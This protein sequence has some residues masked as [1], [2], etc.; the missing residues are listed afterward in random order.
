MPEVI[1][2]PPSGATRAELRR[3]VEALQAGS[4]AALPDETGYLVCGSPLHGD[5]MEQLGA[6]APAGRLSVFVSDPVLAED[7][8]PPGF[9]SGAA[10]RLARRC[11][12]G[13]IVLEFP[14]DEPNSAVA[15]WPGGVRSAVTRGGRVRLGCSAQGFVRDVARELPWPLVSTA[16]SNE[17]P[18]ER[19]ESAAA[20]QQRCGARVALIVDAGSPRYQDRATVVRIE[21]QGWSLAEEGIVG[22]RTVAQLAS[23]IIVFICTGNTCRSPMAEGM[24]RKLLAQRLNCSEEQLTDR[25][26]VVLS[27]GLA[28]TPG[29]GANEIAVELMREDGIDLTSHQS[30][31]A[32]PDLL[33]VADHIVTMT[34]SHRE[35]IV[36]RFP[37][38]A[39][40]V[41]V[42]ADDGAD[43]FDPFGGDRSEYERCRD[44]IRVHLQSLL[45]VMLP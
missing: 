3:T 5:A 25:G 34:R 41:R 19:F 45:P 10:E 1:H 32:S 9:W 30:Q 2:I 33:G 35:S 18:E 16:S 36:T 7:F 27:A 23:K 22:R 24:F 26:Y 39:A 28:T 44:E 13:P 38:S 17:R 20:V 8:S 37:E 12:P 21:P 42:L 14:A 43:V 40:R 11:W 29:M 31:T 15:E 4:L 6:V